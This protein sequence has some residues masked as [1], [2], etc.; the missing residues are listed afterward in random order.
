MI[1]PRIVGL[2]KHGSR[3]TIGSYIFRTDRGSDNGWWEVIGLNAGGGPVYATFPR[4]RRE[5]EIAFYPHT[6]RVWTIGPRLARL[7]HRFGWL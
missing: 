5:D 7:A 4:G 3:L 6:K 2:P 1:L